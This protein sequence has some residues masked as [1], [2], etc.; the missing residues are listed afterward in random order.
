MGYILIL[1][2]N[3]NVNTTQSLYA[4]IFTPAEGYALWD[5]TETGNLDEN[6]NPLV[7]WYQFRIPK[8]LS[9]EKSV[10]IWAKL[11]ED[12]MGVYGDENK[13]EVC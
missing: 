12:G 10:H 8:S 9:E 7:Y 6:G 11:I 1:N 5:D 4:D 3:V 13:Q 2:P